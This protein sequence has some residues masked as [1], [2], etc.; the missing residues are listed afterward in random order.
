MASQYTRLHVNL[1]QYSKQENLSFARRHECEADVLGISSGVV[2]E[3]FSMTLVSAF[4]DKNFLMSA[5]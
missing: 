3:D 1:E 4:R 2:P 5:H